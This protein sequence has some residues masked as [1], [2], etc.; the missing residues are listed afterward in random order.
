MVQSC[1]LDPSPGFS[2]SVLLRR[3]LLMQLSLNFAKRIQVFSQ[4]K[5]IR[6]IT[7][8]KIPPRKDSTPLM[9]DSFKEY[10]DS[11]SV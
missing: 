10:Y 6:M 5:L 9:F 4:K 11:V 8:K 7:M 2:A 1:R 3:F